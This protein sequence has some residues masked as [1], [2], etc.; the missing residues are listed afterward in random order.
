MAGAI[1]AVGPS[2]RQTHKCVRYYV[3]LCA[4]L[5]QIALATILGC[6]RF[7]IRLRTKSKQNNV[8]R[9][10]GNIYRNFGKIRIYTEISVK[11][12]FRT[13]FR[14]NFGFF[15]IS[16][17]KKTDSDFHISLKTKPNPKSILKFWIRFVLEK[18]LIRS[19]SIPQWAINYHTFL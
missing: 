18:K 16:F 19:C 4:L 10:F 7:Y 9:N 2:I 12:R 8:C 17:R 11:F 1:G 6:V 14:R 3:R 13:K 15:R 5:Y